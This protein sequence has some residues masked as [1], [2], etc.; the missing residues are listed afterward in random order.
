VVVTGTQLRGV[1]PAGAE[2]LGLKSA[3]IQA[4]G[5]PTTNQLLS[6]VPQIANQFNSLP[7]LGTTTASQIQVTR[8]NL[9][10]LPGL[11]VQSGNSTLLLV[12]GHR[13]ASA[14][15]TQFAP[16]ADVVPP[17]VIDRVEIVPDGGSSIYGSDAVGGVIN[18][19]TK[20]RIDGVH[21]DVRGGFAPGG[22]N[23]IN[24]DLSAGK[25]WD[26]GSAYIDWDFAKNSTLLN[27]ERAYSKNIDW[28]TGVPIGR[29]CN[30]PNVT[31]NGVN[32]AYPGLQPNT[33]NACDRGQFGSLYPEQKRNS[34]FAGVTQEL[35]P[36][37][38]LEV[39]AFYTERN[40]DADTGPVQA[41]VNVPS[42]NPFYVNIPTASG[43]LQNVQFNWSD[44]HDTTHLKEWGITPTITADLG[45]NWQLR[46]MWNVGGSHSEY[47]SQ[48]SNP[49]L[50][51]QYGA[52]TTTQ[53]AINPY[54]IA[55]TPNQ[56]LLTNILD[57]AQAGESFV[58][59]TNLRAVADG[60][61][62]SLPGGQVRLAVGAEYLRNNL[63]T[64]NA[65]AGETAA[66]FA[67]TDFQSYSQDV[68][69]VFGEL[70]IPIVGPGNAIPGIQALNISASVRHDAYNDF[71]TT[72]NPKVGATWQPLEWITL[73]GSWG[74]SF[75]APTPVDQL[76]SLANTLLIVPSFLVLPP[77]QTPPPGS[78]LV[79][80]EG[81]R[82]DL[83]PQTA[84]QY[85]VGGD[86]RWP[87][88]QGLKS[89][90]TYYNI[91][92]DGLLGKPPVFFP[93]V[94]FSNFKDFYV[95][96][97]TNA[98]VAAFAAQAPGGLAQVAQYLQPGAPPVFT[99]IDFRT[100][101]LGSAIAR[102]LDFSTQYRR[103]T[104]FGGW[105]LSINGNYELKNTQQLGP[106]LPETDNLFN[107]TALR[108]QVTGGVD[109][110]QLRAQ[111]T[112]N[113]N[114]SY[115]V[116]TG[117]SLPQDSVG[118]FTTFNLFFR[119]ALQGEDWRKNLSFTMN[120]DNVFNTDPPVFKSSSANGTA[121]GSTLGRLV[122]F[123]VHKDF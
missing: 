7:V 6:N 78:V 29:E 39:R 122:Q 97:P 25:G 45:H 14:G 105:D 47:R 112:M 113:H 31:A 27:K 22:Y 111:L 3:D 52:G 68:K 46:G 94:F 23:T 55:A 59:M 36:G 13:I 108:L 110:G 86:F 117:P 98:Q 4:I 48:T 66:D 24:T 91:N 83:Q 93:G 95:I 103:D 102:G 109:Y 9:R 63:R 35:S 50:L 119:Y 115:H 80:L 70:Q 75:N 19:I 85:S 30:P 81:S 104:D 89:S 37:V 2:S 76:G 62:F 100:A 57:Y 20:K 53:T 123:G 8:L 101:N 41:S 92:Y 120:I 1:A 73:R 58:N 51:G 90:I 107:G 44:G 12:D 84:K 87:F 56:Q 118:A 96:N 26:S 17:G 18:L 11:G 88:L 65:G 16:D 114:G 67:A 15:V 72:T 77:G 69:S 28:T 40:T 64:R 54:N 38:T 82:K 60:P 5:A 49:T 121:N 71:G 74:K 43:A 106:G 99:L 79:A 21:V 10:D 33:V 42:T 34:I 32:Y 61:L 116:I